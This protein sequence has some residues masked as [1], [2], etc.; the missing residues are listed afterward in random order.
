M[1][2]LKLLAALLLLCTLIFAQRKTPQL[3]DSI[4]F[5]A[6]TD[7]VLQHTI[8]LITLDVHD[9][10][11][12]LALSEL[13]ISSVLT[14]TRD[15]F[16]SVAAFNFNAAR[17]RTRGYATNYSE[18]YINGLPFNELE[19][20]YT[21]WGSLSGLTDVM[22]RREQTIGLNT[23]DYGFISINGSSNTDIR[24]GSQQKQLNIVLAIANRNYRQRATVKYNTGY[25]KHGW[26]FT[27]AGDIRYAE[28]G[29]IKGTY[30]KGYSGFVG[31]E[32]KMG[33]HRLSLSVFDTP[34]ENGRQ[35]VS[36]T[37]MNQLAGTNYY[38]PYWGYDKGK[39][40]NASMARTNMPVAIFS[41]DISIDRRSS[42]LLTTGYV[43]G[44]R[45]V[46]G[47][48]WY[49]APD[50]RPDY[51]R[52]LPS[53]LNDSYQRQQL[54]A[55]MQSDEHLRQINW[56]RMRL[57]NSQSVETIHNV[58]GVTGNDVAGKRARY[59]VQE[60]VADT[61]IGIG[62]LIFN[63]RLGK[64]LTL[65]T[66]ASYQF[67]ETNNYKRIN[68]LLGGD[69]YLDI[70]QY[71]ERDFP[72]A[73]DNYQSNLNTPNRLVKE[74][75][76]FGY[77]YTMRVNNLAAWS[78][79]AFTFNRIDFFL[80][81]KFSQT[82]F[83]RE[84]HYKTGL[85][86]GNSYGKSAIDSFSNY[87]VKAGIT[88]KID[89]RNYLYASSA[90]LTYAP[91]FNDVYVSPSTRD[92]RQ[93]NITNEDIFS[94]EAGYILNAPS[95]RFRFSGYYTTFKNGMKVLSFYHDDYKNYVNYAI[96]GI[97][98]VH[99]GIETGADIRVTAKLSMKL[100]AAVGNYYYNSRQ[101]ATISLDNSTDVINNEIVYAKNYRVGGSPQQAYSA[102][103][104]YRPSYSC[105]L[106]LTGNYFDQI[107][108]DINPVRRTDLATNNVVPGSYQWNNILEQQKFQGQFIM[109]F[110]GSYSWR[111]SRSNP[112][113]KATVLTVMASIN[114]MLNNQKLVS[115]GY[116]QLRFD[117]TGKDVNKFPPK[118]FYAYGTNYYISL[119]L[120]I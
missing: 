12:P 63:S 29:Y 31:I 82:V 76:K 18:T 68:D 84:G 42:L 118:L 25:D 114:N 45:S 46:S 44:S 98:K 57:I 110:F 47:I 9:A 96:N 99:Y 49:N 111:L 20:G 85:F 86:P 100:A 91:Y 89:G 8:P 21:M 103:F 38:N 83:W 109:D 17:F 54:T 120:K 59:I 87:A 24:A 108:L 77:D 74:G 10:D 119:G 73:I 75:D 90:R 93:T 104:T 33:K 36:V 65:T 95:V 106:S 60:R 39:I 16:M 88:F 30:Y 50:P 4:K 112:S 101:N 15:P 6:E 105:F 64:H 22:R 94:V 34:V 80:A 113:K 27:M 48:D 23:A 116:E 107:W 14:A 37:E 102:G 53:F 1:M 32:K 92:T 62:N 5:T 70:N 2:H 55:A 58:D 97:D 72:A 7:T 51:Y 56:D 41:Y 66:G 28:S 115:G 78:Q 35:G 43:Q 26:A 71:A 61:K 19:R 67:Q 81:G 79:L 40:R 11:N 13:D 3:S 117:F 52:N 69:F